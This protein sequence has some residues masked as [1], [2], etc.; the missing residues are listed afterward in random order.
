MATFE[1]ALSRLEAV[2]EEL[3]RSDVSL[4]RAL[5]LFESGIE[6]LRVAHDELT[7]AEAS[8]KVL[9]RRAEGTLETAELNG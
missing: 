1:Q 6:Q 5:A 8:V 9:V 3:E 7:R 2:V 4:D